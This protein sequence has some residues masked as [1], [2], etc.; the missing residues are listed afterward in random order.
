MA[1][2]GRLS[3]LGGCE[4]ERES[5]LAASGFRAVGASGVLV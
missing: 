1:G 5:Y 2:L 3:R 4:Q